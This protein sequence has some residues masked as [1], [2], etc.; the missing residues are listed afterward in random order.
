M[1]ILRLLLLNMRITVRS[2]IIIIVLNQQKSV[3]KGYM[4]KDYK[5]PYL[6]SLHFLQENIGVIF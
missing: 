3:L 5:Q 6:N 1:N 4:L 2:V